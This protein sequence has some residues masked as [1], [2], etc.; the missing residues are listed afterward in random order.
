MHDHV[1]DFNPTFFFALAED[2]GD[3]RM[4]EYLKTA[5]V[6]SA[7]EVAD[8]G[9]SYF[10]DPKRR[11]WPLHSKVATFLSAASFY[12]Q[13]I[14]DRDVENQIKMAAQAHDIVADVERCEQFYAKLAK[15]AS[16]PAAPQAP[17]FA[18]TVDINGTLHQVY[19]CSSPGE[20][21]KS[22]RLLPGDLAEER[23]PLSFAR[24][25]AR[26]LVKRARALGVPD[27]EIAQRTLEL[28]EE[29]IPDFHAAASI[30][31]IRVKYAA[32][33]EEQRQLYREVVKSAEEA[34]HRGESL[35]DYI[36]L[37][38]ELDAYNGIKSGGLICDPVALFYRGPTQSEVE[39]FASEV[40]FVG[41][42]PLPAE[43]VARFGQMRQV[44]ARLPKAAAEKVVQA[45][46]AAL[47][48]PAAAT[49]ALS[50]LDAPEQLTV[51]SLAL[52]AA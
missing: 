16:A 33:S 46:A 45:S 37:V 32:Q 9:S 22:A 38:G 29:R 25:A 49:V 21:M 34:W 36:D 40:V 26:A 44:H 14:N 18:L 3:E 27:N 41:S 52:E 13:G 35:D 28:G 30:M 4:P 6:I 10:A 47:S 19:P 39:K 17:A 1:D 15:Q 50:A 5:S 11:L 24:D 43:L 48:D 8:L 12:S 2:W 51:L 7:E 23:I 42:Q 31:E 20:V